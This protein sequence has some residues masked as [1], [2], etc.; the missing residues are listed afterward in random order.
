MAVA[1]R[2]TQNAN[3]STSAVVTKPTGCVDGDLLFAAVQSVSTT[4]P[5]A[6]AG[7]TTIRS[8]VISGVVTFATFFK[9]ASGE[10]ATFTFT[11][12]TITIAVVSCFTGIASP[13]V[14]AESTPIL[15]NSTNQ[16][17]P[18]VTTTVDH[19]LL[20]YAGVHGST[21]ATTPPTGMTEPTNGEKAATYDLEVAYL[22][23]AGTAGATGNK[24]ATFSP[25]TSNWASLAA[26]KAGVVD[27]PATH[28]AGTA[29]ASGGTITASA[30]TAASLTKGTATGSGGAQTASAATA[31]SLTAG[32]AT[33]TGTT[34]SATI[35][36]DAAV[37]HGTA[38]A[39]GGS[40]AA[41]ADAGATSTV[42]TATA[43][44]GSQQATSGVSGA[45]TAG[46][47]VAAGGTDTGTIAYDAAVTA[48][49]AVAS[50]GTETATAGVAGIVD[51][52]GAFAT[53]GI[54]S[55]TVDVS[56]ALVAGSA[57]ASGGLDTA[58][59]D[60]IAALLA[61]AATAGG[62]DETATID[63][64]ALIVH[65][66][67]FVDGGILTVVIA[68]PRQIAQRFTTRPRPAAFSTQDRPDFTV[69]G[70]PTIGTRPDS[71]E[72]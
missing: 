17:A 66:T 59:A 24:T 5:G 19:D 36:H 35:G 39:G 63:F 18:G 44:G 70:R 9:I 31:A 64:V 71:R 57:V 52:G 65:G 10:G 42:G 22:L 37:T 72:G 56:G 15:V 13:V 25:G 51:G 58:T 3:G 6:P 8:T 26:F 50:G 43:G 28:T 47:A 53:G 49:S 30:D 11:G 61:G 46:Q 54:E 7:W 60:A 40:H 1:H 16:T 41:T 45:L 21:A 69:A 62:G 33:A 67:A 68:Y 14:D 4:A 2:D 48:G 55:A 23:D 27:A 12:A 29:T 32:A 38:T 20:V 34:E